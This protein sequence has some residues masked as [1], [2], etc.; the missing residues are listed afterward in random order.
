MLRDKSV[1]KDLMVGA[2]REVKRNAYLIE[3]IDGV[4]RWVVRRFR[5]RIERMSGQ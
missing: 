4:W 1:S 2:T 5:V 3:G